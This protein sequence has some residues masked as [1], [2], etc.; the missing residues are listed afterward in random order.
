MLTPRR[1]SMIRFNKYTATNPLILQSFAKA[2]QRLKEYSHGKKTMRIYFA[3][4]L[5]AWRSD[6]PP[7]SNAIRLA[8][9]EIHNELV[10]FATPFTCR[11]PPEGP[12]ELQCYTTTN[13][14]H[15][16]C[17][18]YSSELRDILSDT[19]KIKARG[20]SNESFSLCRLD[21][22]CIRPRKADIDPKK[23]VHKFWK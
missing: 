18:Y 23:I 11:H 7:H 19:I 4:A 14:T 12:E 21:L 22:H 8:I 1:E 5:C 9:F 15:S 2:F 20:T 3:M 13:I 6:W 10:D 16:E 17:A